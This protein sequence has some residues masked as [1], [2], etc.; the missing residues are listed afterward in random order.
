V[1]HRPPALIN[2]GVSHWTPIS[3]LV[4]LLLTHNKLVNGVVKGGAC[5]SSTCQPLLALAQCPIRHTS[6][7]ALPVMARAYRLT[8]ISPAAKAALPSGSHR[9]LALALALKVGISI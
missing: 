4:Q 6:L 1:L 9:T 3:H 7:T 2:Q 8:G 5:L